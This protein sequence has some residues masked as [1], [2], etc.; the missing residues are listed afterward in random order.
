MGNDLWNSIFLYMY[1][2]EKVDNLILKRATDNPQVATFKKENW[3]FY[4][5]E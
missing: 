3:N 2:C 1:I 4:G 5:C